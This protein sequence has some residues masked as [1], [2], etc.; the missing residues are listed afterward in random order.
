MKKLRKSKVIEIGVIIL[1]IIMTAFLIFIGELFL[2]HFKENDT[3]SILELKGLLKKSF[4]QA[5]VIDSG[6]I[7]FYFI[8]KRRIKKGKKPI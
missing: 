8:N 3:V 4:L 2:D 1:F 5:I 6:L 7:F